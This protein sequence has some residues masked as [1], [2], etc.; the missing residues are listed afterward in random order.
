MEGHDDYAPCRLDDLAAAGM[1]VWCL[2]HVHSPAILSEDPLVVYPGTA[3]GAHAKE[4]GPRGCYL[5]TVHGR[6]SASAEFVPT[7]PVMWERV[8]VDCSDASNTEEM[9]DTMEDACKELGF[10]DK[11]LEAAVVSLEIS[12]AGSPE[13]LESREGTEELLE[14]L[15]ERMSEYPVPIF[16]VSIWSPD[17]ASNCVPLSAWEEEG[18]VGDFLRL[19]SEFATDI[20]MAEDLILPLEEELIKVINPRFIDEEAR[21]RRLLEEDGRF[22]AR[23]A[24]AQRL[25]VQA[26]MEHGCGS[27]KFS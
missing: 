26:F 11:G 15:S 25:V 3:Q 20:Q 2:G 5:I 13:T 8:V 21:P 9:L 4:T 24:D 14:I 18:F 19:S 7:A 6:G 1:D 12:G 10:G 23:L 17:D 16:P 27:K 22:A